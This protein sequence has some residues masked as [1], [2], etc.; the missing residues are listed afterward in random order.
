MTPNEIERRVDVDEIMEAV[1][2]AGRP[3]DGMTPGDE[4]QLRATIGKV[5]ARAERRGAEG[6]LEPSWGP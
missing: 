5:L 2:Q 3:L 1:T 6:P 4:S